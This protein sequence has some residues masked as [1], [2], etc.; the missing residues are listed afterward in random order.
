MANF[1]A[2]I[3]PNEVVTEW[4]CNDNKLI[5]GMPGFFFLFNIFSRKKNEISTDIQLI[6]LSYMKQNHSLSICF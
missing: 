2:S 1:E 5:D 3:E 4:Y 6:L